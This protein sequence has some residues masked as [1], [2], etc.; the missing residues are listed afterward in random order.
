MN[1]IADALPDAPTI[2]DLKDGVAQRL[3]HPVPAGAPH[4]V[5]H[6]HHVADDPP[7]GQNACSQIPEGMVAWSPRPPRPMSSRRCV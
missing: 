1:A 5:R 3:G 6:L 2:D 7:P 4:A